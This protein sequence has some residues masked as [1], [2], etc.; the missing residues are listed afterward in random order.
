MLT[1]RAIAEAVRAVYPACL[2][3]IIAEEEAEEIVG[4]EAHIISGNGNRTGNGHS[5]PRGRSSKRNDSPVPQ[6]IPSHDRSALSVESE[7]APRT[8]DD[9]APSSR[10]TRATDV[11]PPADNVPSDPAEPEASAPQ[12]EALEPSFRAEPENHKPGRNVAAFWHPLDNALGHLNQEKLTAFLVN[13]SLI[14]PGQNYK[15]CGP[16]ATSRIQKQLPSFLKAAGF[17]EELTN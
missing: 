14:D 10:R 6:S 4:I 15:Y 17:E 16:M 11:Q 1:A 9:I 2:S 5:L 8:T 3:G 7:A 12:P 13:H